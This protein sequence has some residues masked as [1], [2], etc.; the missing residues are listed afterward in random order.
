MPAEE[1]PEAG[2]RIE[3]CHAVL[4]RTHE[5]PEASSEL[6]EEYPWPLSLWA[7]RFDCCSKIRG[8]W[9]S[10]GELPDPEEIEDKYSRRLIEEA[11]RQVNKQEQTFFCQLGSIESVGRQPFVNSSHNA[12][13]IETSRDG[14]L[15]NADAGGY[16]F[17]YDGTK[18]DFSWSSG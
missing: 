6:F 5:Y 14:L 17:F 11:W 18:T 16:D 7:S 9:F 12:P 4:H 3:P 13:T 15:M 2:W 10:R 1:L 8:V